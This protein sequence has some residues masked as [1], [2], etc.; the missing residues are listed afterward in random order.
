M[1]NETNG[2]TTRQVAERLGVAQ[3]SVRVWLNSEPPRFPHAWRERTARGPV[4]M[5]PEADLIGFKA[6]RRGRPA[7]AA[8]PEEKHPA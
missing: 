3:S 5:I 7:K 4:W 2:L 8:Q 6:R 1:E